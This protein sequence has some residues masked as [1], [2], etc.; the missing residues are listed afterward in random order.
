MTPLERATTPVGPILLALLLST[1][2]AALRHAE[3]YLSK[4]E[5]AKMAYEDVRISTPDSALLHGW[6]FPFQDQG[7]RAFNEPK[8]VIIMVTD[9]TDNMSSLLWHYYQFFR[10]TPWHVLMFD[11]R[12]MGTSSAWNIDTTQV[13]M[14]E[15]LIDLRAAIVYARDRPEFDGNHLGLFGYGAGAAVVLAV[16]AERHDLAAVALRGVYTTQSDFCARAR[17]AKPPVRCGPHP[18]WP[19]EL[20]PIRVAPRITAPVFIVAGEKDAMA[21]PEMGQAVHDLLAGPKQFWSAPKAG[22]EVNELPE[23]IHFQPFLV[24]LH[25]F[26]GLH[27]G[28]GE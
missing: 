20:E 28:K 5:M 10:G 8:P 16:A 11:W 22:G 19:A 18:D 27:L 3:K 9:G 7:G 25:G 13:V 23:V 1:P 26:F 21:P 2:A 15:Q 12:G 14:P 17:A 4:P 6:F 24:K